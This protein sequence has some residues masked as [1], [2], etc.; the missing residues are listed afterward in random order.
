MPSGESHTSIEVLN[1]I[2]LDQRRHVDL[3][4]VLQQFHFTYFKDSDCTVVRKD[5]H[6]SR[7]PCLGSALLA[8]A[9]YPRR[10]L[11][12]RCAPS[13]PGVER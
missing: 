4:F 9:L 1:G 13:K 10:R 7:R 12:G 11:V 2:W 3:K 5:A 8:S 6:L